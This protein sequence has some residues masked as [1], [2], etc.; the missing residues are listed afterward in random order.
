MRGFEIPLFAVLFLFGLSILVTPNP[1]NHK[2]RLR[3]SVSRYD[4]HEPRSSPSGITTLSFDNFDPVRKRN[5]DVLGDGW[6]M[7]MIHAATF[8]PVEDAA[9]SLADFYHYI[10][11][12]ALKNIMDGHLGYNSLSLTKGQLVLS[13]SCP[14]MDI[15]WGLIYDF[16]FE[17][18]KGTHRGYAGEYAIRFTHLRGTAI[19]VILQVAP[20]TMQALRLAHGDTRGTSR[21]GT[22]GGN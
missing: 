20:F 17:M 14:Q 21:V 1:I 9:R 11:D 12:E 2:T 15:P 22:S 7:H 19:D 10:M 6:S 8:L 4:E 5:N 16:A 18:L 3:N 13:W